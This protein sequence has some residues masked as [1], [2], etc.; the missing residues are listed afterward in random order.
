MADYHTPE[1]LRAMSRADHGRA[2][3]FP[4]GRCLYDYVLCEGLKELEEIIRT[5]NENGYR[6]VSVSRDAWTYMVFFGRP[7]I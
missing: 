6:L 7:D 1:S 5:I 2:H 4:S 3:K